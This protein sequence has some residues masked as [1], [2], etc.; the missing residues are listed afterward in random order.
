MPEDLPSIQAAL[1]GVCDGDTVLVAP[2]TY[3]ES[4]IEL[5]AREILLTGSDPADSAVV[6][7]TVI[8]GQGAGPVIDIGNTF[9]KNPTIRGL[10]VTGGAAPMGGGIIC[11]LGALPRIEHCRIVANQSDSVGGGVYIDR[12]EPSFTDCLLSLNYRAGSGGAMYLSEV[13]R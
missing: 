1:A 10:T 8:D 7:A 5:G 2:G 6:A 12:A 9:D 3:T 13:E 11:R 4:E